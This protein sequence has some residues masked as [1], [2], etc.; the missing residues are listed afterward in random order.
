MPPKQCPY[1]DD[2]C[3]KIKQAYREINDLRKTIKEVQRYLYIIIGMIA[4]NWGLILW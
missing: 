4:V 1:L 2:N 3:P